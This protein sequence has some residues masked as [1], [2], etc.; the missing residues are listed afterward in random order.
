MKTTNITNKE[1]EILKLLYQFRFLNRIQIQAFLKHKNKKRINEWLKDLTEKQYINRIYSNNF[2]ENTKPAIYYIGINGIRF[3]KTSNDCLIE[4]VRKLY[5]DKDRS[6]QFMAK[7]MLLADI[8]LHLQDKSDEETIFTI[9]TESD[10]INPDCPYHFLLE[11]MKPDLVFQKESKS[12]K[13]SMKKYYLL[14]AFDETLPR[15]SVRKRIKNYLDFYYSTSWESNTKESFP[16]LLF[17]CPTLA[18]LIYAK[19]FTKKLLSDYEDI[20]LNIQFATQ[21]EA[22]E[23]GITSEIWEE[24]I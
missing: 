4:R 23:H 20:E 15:Y 3:L 21:E 22:K 6:A 1:K 18:M 5:R 7:S 17:I 2:G 9:A 13:K 19:R 12:K 11:E 8:C 24:V 14:E 16:T 10:L